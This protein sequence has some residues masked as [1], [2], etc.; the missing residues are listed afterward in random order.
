MNA[1]IKTYC[2]FIL[3]CICTTPLL[4]Q[5]VSNG[6]LSQLVKWE[7]SLH[8]TLPV[9]KLY[10]QTDK[11]IYAFGDTIWLKAYLFNA[12]YMRYA[13]RSGLLYVEL[14]N[15]S[16]SIVRRMMLPVNYGLSYGNI[17][18]DEATIPEGSYTLRAY[19]NW[20]RNFGDDAV[21]TKN[22]YV[23]GT[24]PWLIK[25]KTGTAITD[26][27]ENLQATIAFKDAANQTIPLR[28]IQLK[29]QDGNRVLLRE[30]TQTDIAGLINLNFPLPAKTAM[31]NLSVQV[32]D[33]RKGEDNKLLNIP[34]VLNRP[35]NTDL[36]FMPEGGSL[37]A[38]ITAHIGFKA[39]GEDGLGTNISGK[40]YNSKQEEIASFTTLHKGMGSFD[41]IPKSGETY[42]AKINL[43]GGLSKPYA[44]PQV[45]NSGTALSLSTVPTGDSLKVQV[46]ATPDLKTN[47]YYLIGQARGIICY[48]RLVGFAG[49][50]T[51]TFSLS[52]SLFPSGIARF[53]LLNA[54]GQA[55][56]ERI[57]Y[58]D[59]G[60]N[61]KISLNTNKQSYAARDSVAMQLQVTDNAGK[62][63]QG[64]FSVAVTDNE[65][66]PINALARNGII[67][68]LMLTSDL[69]GAVE[70]PGYYMQ[71]H[72]ENLQALDNLL[73]TQGWVGYSWQQ[74]TGPAQAVKYEA[75]HSFGIKGSVVN[76]LNKPVPGSKVILAEKNYIPIQILTGANGRFVFEN[77]PLTD[78]TRFFLQ[79]SNKR[80]G[81]N[82]VVISV[83]QVSPPGF[84][85]P[86]ARYMPWF[87]NTDTTLQMATGNTLA[88]RLE[89]EKVSG[90][91]LLKTV[92]VKDKK[93]I[94]GSKNPN[95]P[96]QADQIFDEKDIEKIGVNSLAGMLELKVHGLKID[97]FQV[98]PKTV[99]YGYMIG[100]K[101]VHFVIDGIDLDKLYGKQQPPEPPFDRYNFLKGYLDAYPAKEITGIEVMYTTGYDMEYIM[102]NMPAAAFGK[103]GQTADP[104]IAFIE[105][106]TR[107]GVGPF[108]KSSPGTYVYTPTAFA[109]A[110]QFYRPRY[111]V[112]TTGNLPDART[113]IHWEPNIVTDKEGKAMVSF[114]TSDHPGNYT[115]VVEGSDMN[116]NIG[117]LVKKLP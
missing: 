98:D 24:R 83:D 74:V 58:I 69:K 28:E 6:G 82:G 15:D 43:P 100:Q 115:V 36:Q 17:V 107:G 51:K 72:P 108:H 117:S 5:S 40:I 71:Q 2:L 112:K 41:L 45:K 7:D 59:H 25:V 8:R 55:L 50:E 1:A 46:S 9:E 61:L 93:T 90:A 10:I 18:L 84:I 33:L 73:L 34:L 64:S 87:V 11:P 13:N 76:F 103:A 67:S 91:H 97:A 38:G 77:V 86:A 49:A 20:M 65:Q 42:T 81:E 62:P 70:E 106:T 37:V 105:I 22:I 94:K 114:Y 92:E 80:G 31:R 96:G 109:I 63:I 111:P 27:K 39:I 12:D 110:K 47:G 104:Q 53:S 66:V 48:A 89:Q 3:C 26:G 23:T 4:A 52:K 68:T 21:F 16:A 57:V 101:E 32:Q 113:T 30:K 56:N 29:A 102:Q 60:D 88:R 19:T 85:P 54:Q 75:E 79:S 116:G 44:L 35:E 99:R 95:G 78:T 14:T